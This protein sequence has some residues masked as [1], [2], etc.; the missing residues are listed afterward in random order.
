[1]DARLSSRSLILVLL[2][3]FAAFTPALSPYEP[4]E[5]VILEEEESTMHTS[6]GPQMVLN[7]ENKLGKIYI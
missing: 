2:M 4:Q 5:K 1:M 3:L 7:I 6:S